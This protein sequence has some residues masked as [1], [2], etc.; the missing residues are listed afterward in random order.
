MNEKEKFLEFLADCIRTAAE[1]Y[2][3]EVYP[4]EVEQTVVNDVLLPEGCMHV[5]FGNRYFHVMVMEVNADGN[6]IEPC[7]CKRAESSGAII[8]RDRNCPQHGY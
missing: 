5:T 6:V 1:D 8:D 2:D 4:L 3:A 7:T